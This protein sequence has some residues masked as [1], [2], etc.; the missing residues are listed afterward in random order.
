MGD[1][2]DVGARG[3]RVYRQLHGSRHTLVIDGPKTLN[4]IDEESMD[5]IRDGVAAAAEDP[6]CRLLVLQ[7]ANGAFSSGADLKLVESLSPRNAGKDFRRLLAGLRGVTESIEAAEVPVVAAID[8][9]CVGG[10]LEIALACDVRLG[11]PRSRLGLPEVRMGIIPDLGGTQ[12]LASFVGLGRARMLAMTGSILEAA[13]AHR[14]GLLDVLTEDI[15]RAL[16]EL[17]RTFAGLGPLAVGLVKRAVN[18]SRDCDLRTGL[19]LEAAL[20]GQLLSSE[21]FQEGAA[22]LM[23]KRPPKF[24]AR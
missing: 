23:A 7:G 10:G 8:G 21:D 22:A 12:R 16:D 4:A 18:A 11:T 9:V 2:S 1:V 13:E 17:E 20:Q 14:I 24:A 5:E 19:E 3:V 15:E 6:Q